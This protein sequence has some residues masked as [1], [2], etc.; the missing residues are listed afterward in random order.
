MPSLYVDEICNT[1]RE[2]C[3]RVMPG[4][5]VLDGGYAVAAGGELERRNSNGFRNRG[6]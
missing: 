5:V 6:W 3:G 4:T 2:K 1:F